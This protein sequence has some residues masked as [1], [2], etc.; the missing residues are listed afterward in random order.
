VR[1]I[2]RV[3][4]QRLSVDEAYQRFFDGF[5]NLGRPSEAF[6]GTM[7]LSAPKRDPVKNRREATTRR[8]GMTRRERR[9][10]TR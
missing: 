7:V 8:P 4:G 10:L 2:D 1:I 3:T 9:H 6:Q 5:Y